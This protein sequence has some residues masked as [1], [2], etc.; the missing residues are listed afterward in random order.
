VTVYV[1][2]MYKFPMGQYRHPRTGYVMKMSHMIATTEPEL[3]AMARTIEVGRQHFQRKPS[4]DHYDI[5]MTKR[6]LAVQHGAV[7]ISMQELVAL[8][9]CWRHGYTDKAPTE[10]KRLWLLQ[11]KMMLKGRSKSDA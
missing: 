10:A 6:A 7:E 2:D 4:G 8:I 11:N 5:S 9:W 1:D 3:H